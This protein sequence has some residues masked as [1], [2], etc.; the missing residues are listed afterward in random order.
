MVRETITQN[1][2][3]TKMNT[4]IYVKNPKGKNHGLSLRLGEGFTTMESAKGYKAF[5]TPDYA[6][7]HHT[8]LTH[9][10]QLNLVLSFTLS[11]HSRETR[12]TPLHS[13]SL[14]F[15]EKQVIT[16]KLWM[17]GYFSNLG[18]FFTTRSM[19]IYRP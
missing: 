16:F 9:T 4:M 19:P 11:I 13:L 14:Y 18:Y 12:D 15:Q 1:N 6:N 8:Q 5:G 10:L 7:F 2:A 3:T 17:L